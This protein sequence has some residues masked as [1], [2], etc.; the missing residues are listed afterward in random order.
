MCLSQG[1]VQPLPLHVIEIVPRVHDEEV[2]LA[3]IR[4]VDWLVDDQ[5]TRLHTTRL[6]GLQRA[7][8]P[9]PDGPMLKHGLQEFHGASCWRPR[10]SSPMA[11]RAA[12]STKAASP[13]PTSTPSSSPSS[14]SASRTPPATAPHQT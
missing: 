7:P 14:T 6:S 12:S 3:V 5:P 4:K 13:P 8:P 9:W 11:T 10:T 1:R 2:H